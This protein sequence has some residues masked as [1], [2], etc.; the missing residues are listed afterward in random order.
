MPGNNLPD[1]QANIHEQVDEVEWKPGDGEHNDDTD[2]QSLGFVQ[3]QLRP[4]KELN[5][6]ESMY[7]LYNYS[8]YL[9]KLVLWIC[10][11]ELF[12]EIY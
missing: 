5:L 9:R 3:L 7:G 8:L 11:Q 4:G 6:V 12:V 2:Q 10:G 1:V